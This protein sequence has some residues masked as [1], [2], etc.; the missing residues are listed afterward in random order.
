MILPDPLST[1]SSR[2][3][4]SLLKRKSVINTNSS[5][6]MMTLPSLKSWQKYIALI[7][8]L[9]LQNIVYR[10]YLNLR[11]LQPS[12]GNCTAQHPWERGGYLLFCGF[13]SRIFK[14]RISHKDSFE[15]YLVSFCIETLRSGA[16][17]T[18]KIGQNSAW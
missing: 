8:M 1:S 6:S 2:L 14:V 12:L 18:D 7:P 17:L 5:N 4:S 9:L 16:T 10:Q 3:I 15:I 13:M 11:L